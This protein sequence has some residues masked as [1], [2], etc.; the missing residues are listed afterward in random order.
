MVVKDQAK[1]CALLSSVM[2]PSRDVD[3][4]GRIRKHPQHCLLSC[5]DLQPGWD[6]ARRSFMR[7]DRF[8]QR[9]LPFTRGFDTKKWAGLDLWASLE[10][11]RSATSK[12]SVKR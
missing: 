3:V 2:L 11:G 6:V 10:A 4:A 9:E 8:L 12:G 5:M 7:N 1:L